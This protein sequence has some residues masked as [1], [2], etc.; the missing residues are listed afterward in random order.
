MSGTTITAHTKMGGD[1]L[2]PNIQL[3]TSL[4]T[5]RFSRDLKSL[6]FRNKAKLDPLLL[7]P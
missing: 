3:E 6:H 2:V 7:K 4:N 1:I 5:P